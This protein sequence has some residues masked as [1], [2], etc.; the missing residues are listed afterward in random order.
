MYNMYVCMY[1][2]VRCFWLSFS[3]LKYYKAARTQLLRQPVIGKTVSRSMST[4][5][6]LLYLSI[7]SRSQYPFIILSQP[8][9]PW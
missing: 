1:V 7:A 9:G 6:K 3:F 5:S 2:F 8:Q 4:S